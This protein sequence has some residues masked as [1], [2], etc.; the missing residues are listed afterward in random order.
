[1]SLPAW[2]WSPPC[3]RIF[4]GWSAFHEIPPGQLHDEG[5]VPYVCYISVL[6][7]WND[8]SSAR[9]N[10]KPSTL[11]TVIL[12]TNARMISPHQVRFFM[13]DDP[14]TISISHTKRKSP[15]V[16][17]NT[18]LAIKSQTQ[19]ESRCD[20]MADATT[21]LWTAALTVELMVVVVPLWHGEARSC[22]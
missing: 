1:M 20:T 13:H 21:I 2:C 10:T 18:T 11:S 3:C 14:I 19:P 16:S 8:Y 7:R 17:S 4:A 15:S 12:L 9:E 5:R 6:A 22:S